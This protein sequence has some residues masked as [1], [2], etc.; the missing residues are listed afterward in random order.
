MTLKGFFKHFC[1]KILILAI[2]KE[3]KLCYM[4]LQFVLVQ[5]SKVLFYLLVKTLFTLAGVSNLLRH[6][7][8]CPKDLVIFLSFLGSCRILTQFLFRGLQQ[9]F[10]SCFNYF[11]AIVE[12]CEYLHYLFQ[13]D[14]R[15]Q[16]NLSLLGNLISPLMLSCPVAHIFGVQDCFHWKEKMVTGIS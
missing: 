7:S 16:L 9:L 12:F 10:R 2:V 4:N 1:P 3:R 5:F 6:T 14:C 13:F 8:C 11:L 15:Y